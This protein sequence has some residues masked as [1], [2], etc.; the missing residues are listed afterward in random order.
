[1]GTG[2]SGEPTTSKPTVGSAIGAQLTGMHGQRQRSLGRTRLSSVHRTV[3][4]VPRGPRVQRSAS[5]KKET[6]RALFMSVGCDPHGDEPTGVDEE[7]M[8]YKNLDS[9]FHDAN[10]IEV[11]KKE[12]IDFDTECVPEDEFTM[13][14]DCVVPHTTHHSEN[15]IIKEG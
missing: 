10:P 9:V 5:P 2:L 13:I 14:D 7:W 3:S 1:V 4:G 6:N 12:D 8:Y 11:Q 15:L